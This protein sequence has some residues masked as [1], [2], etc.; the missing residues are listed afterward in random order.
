M[1]KVSHI[2]IYVSDYSKSIRFY[3]LILPFIGWR[4]LVCQTS[5]T[6]FTD[7]ESKI[8]FCPVEEKYLEQGYHRKRAGLNHLA[9]F[10]DSKDQ[11]DKL[12]E[13]ILKPRDITCLYEGKPTGDLEYYAVFFE[14]P[15]RIKV[16]VV[17]AP[18]YCDSE[19]WTNK[20]E[21]NFDP[22]AGQLNEKT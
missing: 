14:D 15:D 7:G 13:E 22:Y 12:Y 16:E 17:F 6:T 11:V 3:D 21:D 20:L 2:E 10:A 9:F 18:G 8:V 5:H 19:H 4:R 1:S